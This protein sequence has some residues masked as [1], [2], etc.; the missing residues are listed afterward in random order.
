MAEVILITLMRQ[1][2]SAF[3][4]LSHNREQFA[5]GM[6]RMTIPE[7][8]KEAFPLLTFSFQGE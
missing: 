6:F 8:S 7:E 4:S 1:N 3:D 2:G 5:N